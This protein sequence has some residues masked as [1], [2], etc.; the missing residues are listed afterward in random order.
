MRGTRHTNSLFT[1][2][3]LHLLLYS[4]VSVLEWLHCCMSCPPE[5]THA[6]SHLLTKQHATHVPLIAFA[7]DTFQSTL[8]NPG[9]KPQGFLCKN[10][11]FVLTQI[12]ELFI[13]AVHCLFLKLLPLLNAK[14]CA[15]QLHLLISIIIQ[16][17]Y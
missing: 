12:Q 17:C 14:I 11:A 15:H 10:T 1:A 8:F 3:L 5:C 2:L 13:S 6:C 7:M 16:L 4:L 9:L